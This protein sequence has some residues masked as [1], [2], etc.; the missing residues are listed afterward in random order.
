M[1]TIITENVLDKIRECK[2][3]GSIL[4]I[5]NNNI[6]EANVAILKIKP[7]KT[8]PEVEIGSK[9]VE[10][11]KDGTVESTNVVVAIREDGN[12]LVYKNYHPN[13]ELSK[14]YTPTLHYVKD[15]LPRVEQNCYVWVTDRD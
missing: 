4:Q 1:Q 8:L 9:W 12:A 14:M 15:K 10:I 5:R 2:T 13:P 11:N 7:V 6:L 3:P